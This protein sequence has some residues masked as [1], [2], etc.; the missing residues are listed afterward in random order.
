MPTITFEETYFCP[1]TTEVYVNIP[2]KNKA[3]FS[4]NYRFDSLFYR[5]IEVLLAWYFDCHDIFIKKHIGQVTCFIRYLPEK[6]GL[7]SW[8]GKKVIR[9]CRWHDTIIFFVLIDGF[10]EKTIRLCGKET[11]Q[12][13]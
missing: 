6:E 11:C 13:W 1:H 5:V 9:H 4:F 3:T 10:K 12:W 7:L 2:E 8:N